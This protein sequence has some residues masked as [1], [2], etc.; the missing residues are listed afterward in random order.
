MTDDPSKVFRVVD[1][2]NTPRAKSGPVQAWFC[3]VCEVDIGV[4]T[5]ALI[6]I[7]FA[8]VM[9]RGRIAGGYEALVCA[10]CWRRGKTTRAT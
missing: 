8:P 7:K 10:D 4:A 2:G 3:R 6:K 9:V 5:S 1:G